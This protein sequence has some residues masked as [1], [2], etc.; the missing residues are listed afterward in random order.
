MATARRSHAPRRRRTVWVRSSI[1]QATSGGGILE[2]TALMSD[3]PAGALLGS[4]IT[5]IR[6]MITATH[7]SGTASGLGV[8]AFK[9]TDAPNPLAAT[10]YP[11][12]AAGREDDWLG[13][14]PFGFGR[15]AADTLAQGYTFDIKGMRRMD[16]L[17]MLLR[18]YVDVGATAGQVNIALVTSVLVT[19][20]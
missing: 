2:L 3:A 7:F 8:L 1:G 15:T 18:G 11:L 12:Q 16:E 5:R 17:G 14:V 13:Y 6:G 10:E 19:L 20:P 4:T 9:V